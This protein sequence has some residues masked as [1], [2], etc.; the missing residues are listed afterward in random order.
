MIGGIRREVLLVA[1]VPAL[2]I[3][4]VLATYFVS[5]QVS[6]LEQRLEDQGTA[7]ARHLAPASEFGVF[8]GNRK[9][10]QH[11]VSVAQKESNVRAVQISFSEN[12][13]LVRG[14]A[15]N[16]TLARSGPDFLASGE[17]TSVS[18]SVIILPSKDGSAILFRAPIFQTEME[19]S[20]FPDI[21]PTGES[22]LRSTASTLGWVS[23]ELSKEA[24][25][26]HQRTAIARSGLFVVAVLMVSFVVAIRMGRS[27]TGP[28]VQLTKMVE[29]LAKGELFSR[30]N[31]H[32]GAEL[33]TLEKGI[34]SM[35]SALQRAQD[36]LQDEVS[37]ATAE[38]RSTLI[39][40]EKNN[41]ELDVQRSHA[42]EASKSK[43]RF[44]AN[45]SHELRTPLNA[46]IGYSEMLEEDAGDAG[47]TNYIP[48]IQKVSSAGRHLLSLIND[49]LDL[50]KV[51]AGKMTLYLETSDIES[52]ITSASATIRPMAEHNNNKLVLDYNDDIGSM[53]VDVTKVRQILFN[54]LS[55]ACKFTEN[56]TITLAAKRVEIDSRSWI[57]FAVSDTGIGMTPKQMEQLFEAFSQ[58]D[59]SITKKYGGTGLGLTLCKTF[60][61]LMGGDIRVNSEAGKGSTFIVTLP[62]EPLLPDAVAV[63]AEVEVSAETQE[64]VAEPSRLDT[65]LAGTAGER[66]KKVSKVLIIDDDTVVH[67][68]LNRMFSKEGF[69]VFSAI[70][71]EEGLIRAREIKPNAIVLDVLMPGMDGWSVLASLKSDKETSEIP[72]IMLSMVDDR[73]RGYA[74]GVTEYLTK[75]ADKQQLLSIL[76]RSVREGPT[77]PI[78]VVDDDQNQRELLRRMLEGEGWEVIAA[79][80]GRAAIE[81]VNARRPACIILDILMPEMDGIQFVSELRSHSD[82]QDIPIAVL[83]SHDLTADEHSRLN[84]E[85]QQIMQKGIGRSEL[86]NMVR[87]MVS[88]EILVNGND[89]IDPDI[90][91][92]E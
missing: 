34:N 73:T 27:V 18:H 87:Q 40:L 55:N 7:I 44:L 77:A 21:E 59:V 70:S 71:G 9:L 79:H 76:R 65:A 23:V 31:T 92:P 64:P 16:R 4:V 82:Y 12:R 49:I 90:N 19:I 78:L 47:H 35:A 80:N 74:M 46:I 20:D 41:A 3:A 62:V 52:V 13:A 45:M 67:D 33:L 63:E 38:L 84:G 26:L 75:P 89:D 72:V 69:E 51:E 32:A 22:E 56:G 30:A 86:L 1:L 68:M 29:Q 14:G 10:L 61:E 11:L 8:S 91:R 6:A 85:V 66:R 2:S 48:D 53:R 60:S 25:L 17:N 88:R 54:L 39:A 43:S 24:T 83:T 36:N 42:Q 37:S 57:E 81:A 15:K 28:I 5:V 50:S 58:A